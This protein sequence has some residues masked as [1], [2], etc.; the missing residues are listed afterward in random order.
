MALPSDTD[1]NTLDVVYYGAPYVQGGLSSFV[2]LDSLDFVIFG[3]PYVAQNGTLGGYNVVASEL[4]RTIDELVYSAATPDEAAGMAESVAVILNY[5]VTNDEGM[6]TTD[7]GVADENDPLVEQSEL[8]AMAEST[9]ILP[10]YTMEASETVGM[11]E[12]AVVTVSI[13][14]AATETLGTA[15]STT[16]F[17][18]WV[19][20]DTVRI[21]VA[22]LETVYDSVDL[23]VTPVDFQPVTDPD[24]ASNPFLPTIVVDGSYI[25]QNPLTDP[26]SGFVTG[27]NVFVNL[28]QEA[29][30]GDET[31]SIYSFNMNLNYNGGTWSAVTS[32]PIGTR[33]SSITLFGLTGYITEDGQAVG[34]QG[35]TYT[36][37]GIFG[38]NVMDRPLQFYAMNDSGL[39]GIA[40]TQYLQQPS[41]EYWTTVKAACQSI[42]ASAGLVLYWEAQDAPLTDILVE[43]GMTVQSALATL[44]GRVGA[45][46]L[47]NGNNKYYV[48]SPTY[49][50]GSWTILNCGL[51]TPGGIQYSNIQNISLKRSVLFPVSERHDGEAKFTPTPFYSGPDKV[52]PCGSVSKRLTEDDPSRSIALLPGYSAIKIRIKTK[53]S[54]AGTYVT[55]GFDTWF[56][57]AGPIE[58][59][60]DGSE[61]LRIDSSVFPADGVNDDID[62]GEFT[63][64][65]GIVKDE[66]PLQNTFTKQQAEATARAAS[67]LAMNQEAVRYVETYTGSIS[68]IFYGSLP[69]PGMWCS[70]TL[71]GVEASGICQSVSITSPGI[72]QVEI[73]RF[74]ALNFYQ[75]MRAATA[76]E[77]GNGG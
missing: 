35:V 72:I 23:D 29:L 55:T 18:D 68:A 64:E 38:S 77:A 17:Q 16:I 43:S 69:L 6:S 73:A 20:Y 1:L 74:S 4:V 8:A 45:V 26:G 27:S 3:S 65:V 15:E 34:G 44:A 70:A 56:D 60:S 40:P 24:S 9:A 36:T 49:Q 11:A 21:E 12:S 5:I 57:I 37:K 25:V 58:R 63:L 47:W 7:E 28:M 48:C 39:R 41:S 42:A 51:L 62:N 66:G 53:E 33:G 19:F 54:T 22:K 30:F 61:Y 71:D 76:E 50:I 31:C 2:D 13:P 52:L 46:L 75:P 59:H 10:A 32:A 67:M 14:V